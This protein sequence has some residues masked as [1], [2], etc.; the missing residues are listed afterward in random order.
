MESE[1]SLPCSQDPP[2][3]LCPEPDEFS[4]QFSPYFPK[5]HSNIILPPTPR[6]YQWSLRFRYPNQN[7]VRTSYHI[8]L[9]LIT[10]IIFGEAYKL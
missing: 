10:L 6:T 9:D 7:I 4:P 1:G 3:G 2:T 8:L 5:V